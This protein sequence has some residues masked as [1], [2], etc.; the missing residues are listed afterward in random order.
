[1]SCRIACCTLAAAVALLAAPASADP[2]CFDDSC[3]VTDRLLPAR[4]GAQ[5]QPAAP[6]QQVPLPPV[7]APNTKA[8][9]VGTQVAPV[10]G[11]PHAQAQRTQA[12]SRV[13]P[14]SVVDPAPRR[15]HETALRRNVEEELDAEPPPS[16]SSTK[17]AKASA[18][19]TS[20]KSATVF[21][22]KPL[23]VRG[24]TY[25]MGRR[26]P[27]SAAVAARRP[28]FLHRRSWA[29]PAYLVLPPDP[30]WKLC[31]INH[32]Y[33]DEHF[34]Y[35]TPHSYHPYGAHGYRPYGTYRAYRSAPVYMVGP[36]AKIISIDRDR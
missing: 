12:R 13:V 23:I 9:V 35:C 27:P 7:A 3:R 17:P 6:S 21:R 2:E 34:Y 20:G 31:Q 36:G 29:G 22:R 5:P 26:S 15:P 33:R 14:P 11:K 16:R 1:M 25:M 4:P 32:Y 24:P 8:D 19:S 30:A 10:T 28:G 18:A